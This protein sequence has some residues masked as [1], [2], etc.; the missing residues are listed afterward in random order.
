MKKSVNEDKKRTIHG[1]SGMAGGVP[2][3]RMHGFSS[4]FIYSA[5]ELQVYAVGV[6]KS[7]EP[8]LVQSSFYGR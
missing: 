6:A 2:F 3:F 5:P 8:A 4:R 1:N 7:R